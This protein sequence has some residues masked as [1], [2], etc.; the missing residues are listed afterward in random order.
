MRT[1]PMHARRCQDELVPR[2][3]AGTPGGADSLRVGVLAFRLRAPGG[4]PRAGRHGPGAGRAVPGR[5]ISRTRPGVAGRG[6]GRVVQRRLGGLRTIPG[7]VA[8]TVP[9]VVTGPVV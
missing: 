8:V 2:G 1:R 4:G 6:A 9:V 5:R 7:A 3:G